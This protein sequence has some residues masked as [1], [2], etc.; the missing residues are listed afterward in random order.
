MKMK[1]N[2]ASLRPNY[3]IFIGYLKTEVGWLC[4]PLNPLWIRHSLM[5]SET[6][7]NA[8]ADGADQDQTARS[9]STLFAY[10]NMIR[11]DPILVDLSLF[12]VHT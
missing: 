12:Y 10:G 3:F 8:F 9:E 6:P 7:F 4:E 11:Y 5:S 2:L 1:N